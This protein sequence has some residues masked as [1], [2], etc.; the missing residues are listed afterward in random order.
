[1]M[2]SI[3]VMHEVGDCVDELSVE[4]LTVVSVLRNSISMVIKIMNLVRSA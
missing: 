1:M 2:I 4:M 3:R